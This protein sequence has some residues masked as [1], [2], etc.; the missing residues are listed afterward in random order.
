[1]AVYEERRDTLIDGL[2]SLGWQVAR[3]KATFYVWIPAPPGYTSSELATTLLEKAGI[4]ATPGN[5]FGKN[6]EGF[7]R[8]ALTVDKERLVEAVKRI[9]NI[10]I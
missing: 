8:M 1:M 9:K 3:P 2:Q 6:G 7:I 10:R 5:G 4:V